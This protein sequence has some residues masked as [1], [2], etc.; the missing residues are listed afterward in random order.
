[1]LR[2]GLSVILA[3]VP[4][5]AVV[6][7]EPAAPRLHV[8]EGFA[9]ERIA[10]EPDVVY[11]MFAAFDD[12]G[13]LFVAES[14]GLDL[15]AEL[16]AQTRKCRV[17]V[18]EDPD[19]RGRFRKSSVF[20]DG[21][22]FPMGLVWRDGKLYVADPPDLIT[23]ED[24][25]G[26]GKADRRSVILSGFGHLDNGSLHG[27]T[28]GPDGLLYMTMGS[29][30][31]YRIKRR[32]GVVVHGKTGALLRCRPDGSD[33]EVLCRGFENL[34]EIVF[35]P[36]G[37][38]IGTDNWFQ[39]PSG[40]LR[41]ALV[42]LV[43]GGLYPLHT[44]NT[45]TPQPFT[46]EFLPA[47]SLFPAVAV[48][49]LE[50]YRG[51]AFAGMQ[52][53]LFSAQH[54]ARKVGRHVL[55][56]QGASFRSQDFDFVTSDSPDYH[57]SDVLEDA[58]GSLLVIDTGS[59]YIQHCPTGQIRKV[60]ATGGIDR[61]RKLGAAEVADPRG[62][63]IDWTGATVDRLAGLLA[64]DRP[65]IRDRAQGALSAR[66]P[67]AIAPLAM[68]LSQG[69]NLLAT[70]H[71]LWALGGSPELASLPPLR[72]AL[73]DA[74]PDL[75]ILA[76]KALAVRR[77]AEAAPRLERLLAHPEVAVRL[78]AAEALARC[79]NPASRAPLWRALTAPDVDRFLEHA[80]IHALFHR[81]DTAALEAALRD[82]HPR[83]QQAALI[84]LDQ[85]PRPR[86][87]L[88]H[89]QVTQRLRSP[90]AQLR[91]TATRVLRNHPEWANHSLDLL[92]GW[93]EQPQLE[94]EE[95][96]SLREL[97]LAFQASGQVQDLLG[98]VIAGAK[99][100]PQ[101]RL[102]VLETLA[103][104]SLP[105]TPPAWIKALEQALRPDV[106]KD[107]RFQA[108]RTVAVLQVPQLEATLAELVERTAEP[109]ELRLE[110]LRA[111]AL[112]RPRLSPA[113]GELVVSALQDE[114]QPLVRLAA[115]EIVGRARLTEDQVRRVLPALRGNVVVSPSVVLPALL[116]GA[117]PATAP[118]VQKYLEDSVGKGW[119]PSDQELGHAIK[120]LSAHGSDSA[121]ALALL[122]QQVS[123][124]QRERLAEYEP[125]LTGGDAVRGRAVFLGKQVACAA[126][127]RIGAEGGTI[128]PDLT[129]LGAIRA[130]RDILEAVLV[131]SASIAQGYDPYMLITDTGKTLHGLIS[132]QTAELVV[133]RDASG[134]ELH[135]RKDK[136]QELRRTGVSLMPEGLERALSRDDLR[137]LL[138]FLQGL[139]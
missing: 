57:P 22:V 36:R 35:T 34:V 54:N 129:K 33:P 2:F 112:Y 104:S 15:Y 26:D 86:N 92:R 47:V 40:G 134:A 30:D 102:L 116:R 118:L 127:H 76:T 81:T 59:W 80:L 49:G 18:L 78:A 71:A 43:D 108:V 95:E 29:P 51:K 4:S 46:G 72:A 85:P 110:A 48:S 111:I 68:V 91:Q 1:M 105:K 17:R 93:L 124:K 73:D 45:G 115:A 83:V 37:D 94:P 126:C 5:L 61:V 98:R 52:G 97:T 41:D 117:T 12:R 64:D 10:A 62:L 99:E 56:P 109:T 9:I 107:V 131:P 13:R 82:P 121:A 25:D 60:R 120:K 67:Q 100:P 123:A 42:H 14:S 39:R 137:D 75:I 3:F 89:E 31:G 119:R 8:P 50:R 136:V 87:Q 90:D 70:Q 32:D 7:G 125:L 84:L 69:N 38:M 101:R 44:D 27:L 128:G 133:V 24:T 132:R 74:N 28:F 23:L 6:A 58:D 88:H 96:R 106:P 139:K 63:K 113:V 66:G 16:K 138:A 11:P 77:D 19:E 20:A 135:L 130:G 122:V 55:I 65:V 53:Q 21:L 79:G 114:E 103:A